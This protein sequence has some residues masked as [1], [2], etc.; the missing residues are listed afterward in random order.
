[1]TRPTTLS[2]V[3]LTTVLS[4]A[5]PASAEGTHQH[6]G[7]GVETGAGSD[8]PAT[9]AFRDA[10]AQMHREMD[11]RYS[12]DVDVDFA[13]GMIPHHRGAVAMAKVALSHSKDPEVRRLA[14]EI[15]AAQD[16]EI[17]QM[18]TILKRKAAR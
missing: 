10:D 15:I 3:L 8:T 17:A 16:R 6:H 5:A 2:A 14:E 12:N 7:H 1:M 9:K 13:R 11:I 18:E 4:A